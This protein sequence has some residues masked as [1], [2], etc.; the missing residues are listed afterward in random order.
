M[1]A[2]MLEARL[3]GKPLLGPEGRRILWPNAPS[4]PGA[5]VE[6]MNLREVSARA[7]SG[8]RRR[9]GYLTNMKSTRGSDGS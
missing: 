1:D 3:V 2:H 7:Q 5:P 6:A 8:E 9:L 4:F